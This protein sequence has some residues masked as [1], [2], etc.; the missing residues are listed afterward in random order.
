MG[1]SMTEKYEIFLD[2]LKKVG[3]LINDDYFNI[4]FSNELKYKGYE[5]K[6]RERVYCYE[7]YHKL[8]CSIGNVGPIILHAEIDKTKHHIIKKNYKPDFVFHIPG[9]MED[10][11]F[12]MEVKHIDNTKIM[13][14]TKK[15][16]KFLKEYNYQYGINLLFGT[17]TERKIGIIRKKIEV[18]LEK[19][20]IAKDRFYLAHHNNPREA[21]KIISI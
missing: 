7:L 21:I 16:I 5:I 14:D 20:G 12:I 8:R 4:K 6:H 2:T 17:S 18:E 11:F 15:I 19:E 10:N 13:A 9:E 1:R 3:Y